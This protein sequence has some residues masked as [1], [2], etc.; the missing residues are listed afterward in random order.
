MIFDKMAQTPYL[1]DSIFVG[2]GDQNRLVKSSARDLHLAAR[3]KRANALEILGMLFRQPFEQRTGIV[4]PQTNA[5]VTRHALHK[6]QVGRLVGAFHY[7]VKVANRLVRV[8]EQN[9]VEFRQ[10]R[11]SRPRG[12]SMITRVVANGEIQMHDSAD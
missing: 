7:V 11:T 10:E 1:L 5:R 6:R 12:L 8:N 9:Q 4:Q 2:Y 3:N